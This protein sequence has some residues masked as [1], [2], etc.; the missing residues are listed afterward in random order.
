M[1]TDWKKIRKGGEQTG[2]VRKPIS[3]HKRGRSG[4]WAE[5]QWRKVISINRGK[6]F[7]QVTSFP[8]SFTAK[9]MFRTRSVLQALLGRGEA[10]PHKHIYE[11]QNYYKQERWRLM[12]SP[13]KS[14]CMNINNKNKCCFSLLVRKREGHAVTINTT[15]HEAKRVCPSLS[16]H[17]MLY[18]Y[19]YYSSCRL[20][21]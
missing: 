11:H 2:N 14:S 9:A 17:A 4:C 8:S 1:K 5:L 18:M 19:Y 16:P 21:I 3:F 6:S 10:L 12:F 20:V 15:T 13:L 7:P